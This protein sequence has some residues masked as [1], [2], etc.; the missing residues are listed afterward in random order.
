MVVPVS[1]SVRRVERAVLFI[2]T[3]LFEPLDAAT[4]A[5]AAGGSASELTRLFRRVHGLPPMAYVR[6]RRL[7]E[8]ARLL[9]H[10]SALEVA[11][12]CGYGS[13]AAFT[14]AFARRFGEPPGRF[15]RGDGP[16]PYTAVAPARLDSLAHRA[17]LAAPRVEWLAVDEVLHGLVASIADLEV[18]SGFQSAARALADRVGTNVLATGMLRGA[19]DGL[20]YFVGQHL[21]HDEL[22]V[23]AV[24]PAGPY[25]VFEHV[26]GAEQVADTV[27]YIGQ[28]LH[29][30][31]VR[32]AAHAHAERYVL[33]D[34]LGEEVRLQ[35]WLS[36]HGLPRS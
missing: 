23:R 10:H 22:T 31:L 28:H 26:G 20:A 13:Q 11:M 27:T 29:T 1:A 36:V 4:I 15:A 8:A 6:G 33:A 35:L 25:L 30:D 34:V 7:T 17:G 18:A 5:A 24:L 16:P 9:P 32:V 19:D 2:E 12:R 21:P 14:R 3:R